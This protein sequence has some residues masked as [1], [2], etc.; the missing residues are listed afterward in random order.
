MGA[1]S[2]P[3][4]YTGASAGDTLIP[5]ATAIDEFGATKFFADCGQAAAEIIYAWAHG[6]APDKTHINAVVHAMGLAGNGGSSTLGEESA[7]L[8]RENVGNVVTKDWF[9]AISGNAGRK[10]VEL[11]V[12]APN[13]GANLPGDEYGVHG[14]FLTVEGYSPARQ[15]FIVS[16]P[17]NAAA[18]KNQLVYYTKQQLAAANPQGAI[19]P[20]GTGL[21]IKGG[22][23]GGTAAGGTAAD[24]TPPPA[25]GGNPVQ[26][27]WDGAQWVLGLPGQAAAD[28]GSAAVNS[29]VTAARPF[30]IN[31]GVFILALCAILAGLLLVFWTPITGAVKEQAG[32][33]VDAAKLATVAA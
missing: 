11:L 10:P 18:K 8:Q 28:A 19:V 27:V 16:D 13:L 24:A 25:S 23:P 2:T 32:G 14:H 29:L 7:Q 26:W 17:D 15:S 22:G 6:T 12:N 33:A 1:R 3:N 31:A 21:G 30:V 9:G 4:V 5:G 20:T